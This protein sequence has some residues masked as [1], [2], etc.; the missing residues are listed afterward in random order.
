MTLILEDDTNLLFVHRSRYGGGEEAEGVARTNS[1]G[2]DSSSLGHTNTSLSRTQRERH[3]EHTQ[4]NP[5][6]P[7]QRGRA[8]A[9]E[10]EAERLQVQR[11]QPHQLQPQ[12]V[13][14]EAWAKKEA[15][16]N[17]EEEYA[18]E[19]EECG[20]EEEECVGLDEG[21]PSG[22]S[23]QPATH[24]TEQSLA[25]QVLIPT[26]FQSP[27]IFLL[28][29]ASEVESVRS[30]TGLREVQRDSAQPFHSSISHH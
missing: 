12:A 27:R 28:L 29:K 15:L 14:P 22:A 21:A 7:H 10:E 18:G 11:V 16:R 13:E 17:M 1:L 5:M 8:S 19:E 26:N 6:H 25:H 9:E 23:R 30:S 3:S 24:A 20:G 4:P 2:L